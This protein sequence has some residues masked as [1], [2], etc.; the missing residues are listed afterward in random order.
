VER[1]PWAVP[2]GIGI[3]LEI[4]AL[5]HQRKEPRRIKVPT[6][7]DMTR[8]VFH[9]DTPAGRLAFSVFWGGLGVWFYR[10]ILKP[11]VKELS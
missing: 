4:I 3:V 5:R 1:L 10:H 6:L 11:I 8:W 9:T 7:S 2:F